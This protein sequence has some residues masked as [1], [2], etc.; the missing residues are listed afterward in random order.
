MK[1]ERNKGNREEADNQQVSL[2]YATEYGIIKFY[3]KSSS[4]FKLFYIK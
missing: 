1:G 3:S 2:I 4:Y